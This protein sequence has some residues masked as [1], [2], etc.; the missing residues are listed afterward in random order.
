MQPGLTRSSLR[1]AEQ[2]DSPCQYSLELDALR[3]LVLQK[4]RR[5]LQTEN[6]VTQLTT[7]RLARP[8][9]L[10]PAWKG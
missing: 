6:D 5:L 9:S 10:A 1:A 3:V 2:N 8:V 7:L 4:V